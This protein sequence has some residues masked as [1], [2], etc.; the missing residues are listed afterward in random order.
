MKIALGVISPCSTGKRHI[1][2]VLE[3][4]AIR[5]QVRGVNAVQRFY[6]YGPNLKKLQEDLKAIDAGL[7]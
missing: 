7:Q 5:A 1:K 2:F 4:T 6:L 3:K